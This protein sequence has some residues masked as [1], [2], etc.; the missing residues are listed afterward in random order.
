M[1]TIYGSG[2]DVICFYVRRLCI[3]VCVGGDDGDGNVTGGKLSVVVCSDDSV[4]IG[5]VCS[6]LKSVMISLFG[7]LEGTE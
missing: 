2:G 6:V 7:M 3:M 5:D 4:V 1:V